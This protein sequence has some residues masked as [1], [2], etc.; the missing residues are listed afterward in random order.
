MLTLPRHPWTL[1]SEGSLACQTFYDTEYTV[2]WSSA[3][4]RDTR[5]CWQAFGSSAVT[6]CFSD[7]AL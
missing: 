7:L 4:T 3:R 6:T 2:M 1:S 5:T